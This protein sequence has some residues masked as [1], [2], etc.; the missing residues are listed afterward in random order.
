M[1]R[2]AFAA[3]FALLT[4]CAPAEAPISRAV[5]LDGFAW[6]A[7][8]WLARDGATERWDPPSGPT[9]TGAGLFP[10]ADGTQ[11]A[12]TLRI[13]SDDNAEI[14]FYAQLDGREERS[15]ALVRGALDEAVFENAEAPAPR[16]IVYRRDGDT[17]TATLFETLEPNAQGWSTRYT[18]CQDEASP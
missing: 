10:Q 16:R 13:A 7:G 18:R 1:R 6:L 9:M 2:A 11:I 15:Y 8:C 17:L 3:A 12:E 4:S 14:R 5:P